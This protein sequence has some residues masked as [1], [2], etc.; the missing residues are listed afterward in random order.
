MKPK[1]T[2]QSY[3]K[4]LLVSIDQLGNTI[5]GGNPDCTISARV[6]LH[7]QTKRTYSK[8]FWK[9]EEKLINFTFWPVDG[10][11][12]CKAAFEADPEDAFY[13]NTGDWARALLFV[14]ILACCI[15]ITLVLYGMVLPIK[16]I[17]H[18]K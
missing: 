14:V 5:C 6:G 15:P 11:G 9:L 17:L 13:D 4:N 16:I 1:L 3:F 8:W 18:S 10:A 12:H 2:F 7:A